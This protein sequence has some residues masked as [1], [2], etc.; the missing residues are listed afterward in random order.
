[1]ITVESRD[2]SVAT[3]SLESLTG[4]FCAIWIFTGMAGGA[5][6]FGSVAPRLQARSM[7]AAVKITAARHSGERIVNFSDMPASETE[8][9]EV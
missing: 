4:T 9:N 8:Y 1:M 6:A 7:P 3:Y 5:C 2:L